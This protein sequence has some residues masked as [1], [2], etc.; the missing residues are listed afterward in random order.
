MTGKQTA[1]N[2][3]YGIPLGNGK[4]QAIDKGYIPWTN[5]QGIMLSEVKPVSK[6]YILCDFIYISIFE[7]T[8]LWTWKTDQWLPGVRDEEGRWLHL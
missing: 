4:E 3:Y 8:K 7:M 5:L 1:V 6:G 2:P